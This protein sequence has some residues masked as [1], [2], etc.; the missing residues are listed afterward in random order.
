MTVGVEIDFIVEDSLA[1][2]NLYERIFDIECI[3]VTDFPF[4]RLLWMQG[5]WKYNRL[6]K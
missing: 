1:A 5:V 6:L 4:T 2:L 3:E